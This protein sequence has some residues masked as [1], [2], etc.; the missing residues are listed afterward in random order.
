MWGDPTVLR[1]SRR[2]LP[3]RV[4]MGGD[5]RLPPH[6][7]PD[8]VP[9]TRVV[10]RNP[11]RRYGRLP[12]SCALQQHNCEASDALTSAQ[13]TKALCALSFD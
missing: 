9:R 4:L 1:R 12:C 7:N 11:D 13:R 8:G 2:L 5:A 3:C 6:W 10:L